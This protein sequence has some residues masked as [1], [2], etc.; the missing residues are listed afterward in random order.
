VK[1]RPGT[2]NGR[3]LIVTG[4]TGF[5]GSAFVRYAL[6][7]GAN[8][9]VVA[10]SDSDHWRLQ[11][12]RDQYQIL[13]TT[14]D[15]L[16]NLCIDTAPETIMV[17]F[18][19]AGVNQT[20]DD[21][22]RMVKTNVVGTLSALTFA[23][24]HGVTRFIL[25]GTSGEYGPGVFL[26]EDA[27]LRPTSEYGATRAGATMLARAFGARR[28][29]DVTVVRPFAVFGPYEAP[30]RLIPYVILAALRGEPIQISSGQQ[31]RDYVHVEDVS[32]GIARACVAERAGGEII[33]LCTGIETSV[34]DVAGMITTLVDKGVEIDAGA[35][36]AIPGE[37]WKTSG[38]P[39][40]AREILDWSPRFELNTVLL[41]TIKWFRET[42]T[43]LPIYTE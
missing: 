4:G 33:N 18:A 15:G 35:I 28:S 27:A 30:Y 6:G 41:A 20:D 26:S 36:P 9:Q 12:F 11:N 39:S 22:E 17:H 1:S 23:E 19:A 42:G 13:P 7:E 25:A 31:T 37:M 21:I 16:A 8:V 2:L 10:R 29:L 40:R 34:H 32:A 24:R 5:L 43:K 3:N 14:I 38:D